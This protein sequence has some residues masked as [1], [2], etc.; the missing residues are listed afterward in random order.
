MDIGIIGDITF[1]Q[2]RNSP[3]I[4]S[5]S[6]LPSP[7]L[8]EQSPKNSSHLLGITPSAPDITSRAVAAVSAP[9]GMSGLP[10]AGAG[11]VLIISGKIKVRAA[12]AVTAGLT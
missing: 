12:I 6:A 11:H 10:M 8:P 2:I 9:A 7:I 1:F 3:P 5:I 4:R